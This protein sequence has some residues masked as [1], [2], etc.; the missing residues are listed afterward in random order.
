MNEKQLR[1]II[2]EE[3]HRLRNNRKMITEAG[4]FPI[5]D[6]VN[7]LI[8]SA[9]FLANKRGKVMTRNDYSRWETAVDDLVKVLN[10]FYKKHQIPWQYYKSNVRPPLPVDKEYGSEW[11]E[12]DYS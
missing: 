8:P 9:A 4:R 7:D 3:I 12:D 6:V 10:N 5:S 11:D 2:R 1:R